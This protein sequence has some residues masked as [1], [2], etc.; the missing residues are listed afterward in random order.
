MTMKPVNSV[1]VSS[2]S[3]SITRLHPF[4]NFVLIAYHSSNY[5]TFGGKTGTLFNPS[6]P[7]NIIELHFCAT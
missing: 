7:V 3:A 4:K 2:G 5:H 6:K 1:G